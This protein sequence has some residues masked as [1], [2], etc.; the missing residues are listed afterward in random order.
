MY[1]VQNNLFILIMRDDPKNRTRATGFY[2]VPYTSL[3]ALE[4]PSGNLFIQFRLPNSKQL[5]ASWD[6]LCVIRKDYCKSDIAGEDN[7]PI[8][9][10]L[11]LISTSN[12]SISNSVKAT[13]NLRGIIKSTKSMMDPADVKAMKDQFVEDYMNIQNEGGIAALDNT[14]EFKELNLKPE[15]TT[16][17]QMREFRENCYRYFGV[18]DA[19]LM[20]QQ[21]PEEMQAFYE[22]KIEPFLIALSLEMTGKV[23]TERELGYGNEIIFEASTIQFMS[24]SEK[25]A[26]QAMVDRG[27]LTPNEWR[28]VLNLAP[29]EGGDEPIR[30]LDTA[31][32]SETGITT[33]KEE[34]ETDESGD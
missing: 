16:W 2:P 3:E 13:A 24:T 8:L 17:T 31:L 26:L 32:V 4:S 5:I 22:A 10:T 34:E 7:T 1:E 28:A 9:E 6:D 25:L 15:T 20:S 33:E 29:I 21:T 11:E 23:Y 19:I 18:N 14:M 27:A 12:Q 30:R